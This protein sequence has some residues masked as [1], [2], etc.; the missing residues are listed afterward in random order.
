[1]V[2]LLDHDIKVDVLPPGAIRQEAIGRLELEPVHTLLLVFMGSDIRGQC[3][4]V[5]RR[6]RRM[7]PEVRIAVCVLN[8]LAG[9]ETADLLHVDAL[10]RDMDAAVAAI[11]EQ[12]APPK[13]ARAA[14]QARP[15]AGLGRG[16]DALGKALDDIA[17]S[18]D[19][20][21]AL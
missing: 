14:Q 18:F 3:R 13:A 15:F 10:Y 19:V 5:A 8:D 2:K 21:V 7:D 6:V 16:D 17:E 11:R 1:G 20:P 12:Q 4:Y 9:E